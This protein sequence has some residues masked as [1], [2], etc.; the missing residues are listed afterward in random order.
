MAPCL[1]GVRNA[2]MHTIAVS[3]AET[4]SKDQYGTLNWIMI[5]YLLPLPILDYLPKT[6]SE[7]KKGLQPRKHDH[8]PASESWE[9]L[10]RRY[11]PIFAAM[12]PHK[13]YHKR[14]IKYTFSVMADCSR[15]M[16]APDTA[17]IP[18][19]LACSPQNAD[20]MRVSR[21]RTGDGLLASLL[22]LGYN[23]RD[24]GAFPAPCGNAPDSPQDGGVGRM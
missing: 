12:V 14:L 11:V 1:A 10:I 21:R 3:T 9:P 8:E 18:T 7:V 19:L 13:Y 16:S 20:T 23:E 5:S 15:E 6:V 22:F 17:G 2:R 4:T 24:N